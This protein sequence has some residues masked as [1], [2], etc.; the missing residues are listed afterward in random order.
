MTDVHVSLSTGCVRGTDLGDVVRFYGIPYAEDPVGVL[1]FAAP[2]RLEAWQGVRDATRPAATAQRLRFDPDPGI[3]EQIVAGTDILHVDVWAPTDGVDHGVDH[4]GNHPVMVWIHGGGWESGSSHQPWFD[5]SAFARRGIVV[6]SVGYRLGVE[7]FTPFPD[8][9]D[10]RGVLDWIAALEWVRDEIGAFGGDPGR[11]TVAGQS[12]GGGAVLCLLGS[13]PAAGLFHGAIA[14]SPAVLRAPATFAPKGVTAAALA[15]GGRG[16]VDEFHRRLRRDNQ[17]TLPFR[18]VVGGDTVP[19]P[20]LEAVAGGEAAGVPLLI[21]STATE[22]EAVAD[23]IPGPALVPGAALMALSQQLPRQG[24]RALARQSNGRSLR[25]S[26][27]AVIDAAAIHSTVAR[28]AETRVSAGNPTWVYDFRWAGGNGP[29]HCA[30]LP[31]FWAVPHAQNVERYLGAPPPAS[32]VAAMHDSWA[33]FITNGAPGYPA[34]DSPGRQVM[35]WDDPP[36]LVED[37]L[38]AVREVWWPEAR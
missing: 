23:K 28:A 31:F 20:P 30:D 13:P 15:A 19:L 3:P 34:Y 24:L 4:G 16:A 7:G 27:G 36:S 11:V 26:V 33:D 12:A 22:F 25:R 21:G 18:P 14:A 8:A 1:R 32:L 17:F 10:N 35:A 5:G 38:A 29:R 2:V 9:P 37:G 6:V